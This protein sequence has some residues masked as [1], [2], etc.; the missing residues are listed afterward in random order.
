MKSSI[1]RDKRVMSKNTLAA[2]SQPEEEVTKHSV[3]CTWMKEALKEAMPY[4]WV[5]HG[6]MN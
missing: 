6:A 3:S 2:P 5:P 4:A 1:P